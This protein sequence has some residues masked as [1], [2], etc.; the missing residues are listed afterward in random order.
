MQRGNTITGARL[1]TPGF[2]TAFWR[3]T[4]QILSVSHLPCTGI[5]L[6]S[7]PQCSSMIH[8][9][10]VTP[11]AA[12][13][14]PVPPQQ[15]SAPAKH[16]N[17]HFCQG[18]YCQGIYPKA[19]IWTPGCLCIKGS[20]PQLQ[21]LSAGSLCS[22]E[23]AGPGKQQPGAELDSSQSEA[24]RSIAGAS[25]GTA[26]QHGSWGVQSLQPP[27]VQSMDTDLQQALAACTELPAEQQCVQLRAMVTTLNAD[28][29]SV[30]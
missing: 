9:Q 14:G 2:F 13:G 8:Q 20:Q 11:H 26:L 30:M 7:H 28:K 24:Q 17:I 25:G 19:P 21:V 10:H 16:K 12:L 1:C 4:C 27:A 29:V 15:P 6:A 23:G 5:K 18:M 22:Q 3:H